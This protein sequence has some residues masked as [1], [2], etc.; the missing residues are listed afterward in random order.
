MQLL[1][2]VARLLLFARVCLFGKQNTIPDVA[3]LN[4]GAG[5]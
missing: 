4:F 2:Q 1:Q 5:A 3:K